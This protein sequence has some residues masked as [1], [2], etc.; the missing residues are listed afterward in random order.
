MRRGRRTPSD[1]VERPPTPGDVRAHALRLGSGSYVLLS[2]ARGG[3]E[4]VSGSAGLAG[5]GLTTAEQEVARGLL[6]GLSNV[7]IA[8]LRGSSARTIANQAASLYAKLGVHSRAELAARFPMA[9]SK[10]VE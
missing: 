10:V 4:A 9:P 8:R 7:E 3:E 2:F 5:H 6:A 1:G